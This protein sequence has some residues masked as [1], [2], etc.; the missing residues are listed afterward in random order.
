MSYNNIE[1]TQMTVS[2]LNQISSD[3]I[4]EFDDFWNES[5]LKNE[6]ENEYSYYIVAKLT[7]DSEIVGFAGL[8]II[9]DN[10]DIMNIVTKKSK[11]NL[12][13]AQLM[14]QELINISKEKNVTTIT[15][16]VNYKNEPAIHLY[17]KFNFK[18]IAIRKNYYS[19]IDDAIIMQLTL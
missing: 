11:R 18:Q 2:D 14:L 16:E 15:L 3:L 8:K 19:N 1:L 10:A 4:S 17:Q 5:T 7:T 6:L 13:I 12:G 9:L